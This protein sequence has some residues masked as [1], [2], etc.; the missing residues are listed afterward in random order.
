M[1]QLFAIQT[2]ADIG[3]PGDQTR[4]NTP[5]IAEVKVVSATNPPVLFGVPVK[6]DSNGKVQKIGAGDTSNDVYGT[7]IRSFPSQNYT[8]NQVIGAEIPGGPTLSILRSGYT[9]VKVIGSGTPVANGK[10][11]VRTV[12]GTNTVIGGIETAA[13][14][15]NTFEWVGARFV[16]G[17]DA[18]GNAEIY[19]TV[20]ALV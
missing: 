9:I 20:N 5:Q 10:V 2:R 12:T 7:V 3:F 11:Y 13:D 14:S 16:G 18:S 17:K 4:L 1:T 8:L 19:F 15:T 6:L